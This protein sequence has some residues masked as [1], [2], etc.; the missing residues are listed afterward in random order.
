MSPSCLLR[1]LIYNIK[2]LTQC[3]QIKI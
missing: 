1:L 2:H 3:C